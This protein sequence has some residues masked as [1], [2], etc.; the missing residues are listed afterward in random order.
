MT[1]KTITDAFGSTYSVS[2]REMT[3]ERVRKAL[4][5]EKARCPASKAK[6]S[7]LTPTQK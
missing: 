3:E 2:D 7:K 4:A 5:E 1:H 6:K